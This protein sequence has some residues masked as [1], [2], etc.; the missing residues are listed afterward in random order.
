MDKLTD[1]E[2]VERV[3]REVMGFTA[4][5]GL[6]W[7][8]VNDGSCLWQGEKPASRFNSGRI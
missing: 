3:A 5:D 7:R 6:A 2:L 1:S 8:E 4:H